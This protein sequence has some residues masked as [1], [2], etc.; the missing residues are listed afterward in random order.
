MPLRLL[1]A[2]LL[3]LLLQQSGRL[4]GG[5]RAA[6]FLPTILPEGA[7]ALIWLWILNPLYGP[8]NAVLHA[9]GLP[10]PDWLLN[11][12]T[13]R[14]SLVLMS[15][16]TIG[17]GMVLLL[18]GLKTIPRVIYEAARVDGANAWQSFWRISLPLLTPWLLLLTFRDIVVSLQNTFT[19]SFVMTYGGPY[20]A[21]TFV[22]L[23]VFELAFDLFDFGL[24]AA[25]TVILYLLTSLLVVGI[26]NLVGLNRH[27]DI[28]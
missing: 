21:T 8:L 23:L 7:C 2:L 20:Y 18:V 10:T 17:E 16:F 4:F 6:V 19:P 5:L 27:D 14:M 3:A 22:P 15:L 24:A 28:A 11:P 9:V 26:V 1:S 12:A 13:A 25:M